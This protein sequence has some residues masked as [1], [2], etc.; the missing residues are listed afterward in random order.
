MLPGA[1]PTTVDANPQLT[2]SRWE[3]VAAWCQRRTSMCGRA[4]LRRASR[5]RAV[6]EFEIASTDSPAFRALYRFR[7]CC[8]CGGGFS[9][10]IERSVGREEIDNSRHL[11]VEGFIVSYHH[12]VRRSEQL[13]PDVQGFFLPCTS[14]TWRPCYG[15]PAQGSCRHSP[16]SS[17]PEQIRPVRHAQPWC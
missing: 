15:P 5:P 10:D 14:R 3:N 16:R 13:P 12:L 1:H 2:G 11:S 6:A 17:F 8:G 7:R 4:G 9:D